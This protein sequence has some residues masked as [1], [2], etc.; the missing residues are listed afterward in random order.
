MSSGQEKRLTTEAHII[1][2]KERKE[3]IGGVEE[4]VCMK[5]GCNSYNKKISK[6]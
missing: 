4:G 3:E 1:E 6:N 5:D 2:G